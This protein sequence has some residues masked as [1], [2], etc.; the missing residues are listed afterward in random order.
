MIEEEACQVDLEGGGGCEGIQDGGAGKS[1]NNRR[2][3]H[4]YHHV[5]RS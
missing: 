3:R 1:Q 5:V 4:C 2:A